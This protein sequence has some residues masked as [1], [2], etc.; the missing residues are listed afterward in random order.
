MDSM[1]RTRLRGRRTLRQELEGTSI[2]EELEEGAEAEVEEEQE[3]AQEAEEGAV[4]G[5]PGVAQDLPL[6]LAPM[7]DPE[8]AQPRLHPLP[9]HI[10]PLEVLGPLQTKDM[11]DQVMCTTIL[12]CFAL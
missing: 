2:R 3:V 8:V 7:L 5:L 12:F 4:V 9:V 10:L 11:A 6:L 1:M